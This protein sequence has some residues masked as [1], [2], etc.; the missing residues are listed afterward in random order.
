MN[1][2]KQKGAPEHETNDT[3]TVF[4]S[5]WDVVVDK[6]VRNV[7][8]MAVSDENAWA[9]THPQQ[10]MCLRYGDPLFPPYTTGYEY[11]AVSQTRDSENDVWVNR[12]AEALY[13]SSGGGS[14]SDMHRGNTGFG[15]RSSD[16]PLIIVA[17]VF[18]F[19][20]LVAPFVMS[21]PD[22]A[23]TAPNAEQTAPAQR[24]Y[25]TPE[26]TPV[27]TTGPTGPNHQG[28]E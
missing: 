28:T 25:Y 19:V 14:L 15:S 18:A 1:N 3:L 7:L 8:G 6:N 21:S 17:L 12:R 4:K 23:K 24:T 26:G 20:F 22:D 9:I 13:K 5:D 16:W 10:V 27:P 11:V 2:K